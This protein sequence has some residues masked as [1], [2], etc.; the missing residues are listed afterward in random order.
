MT[1][2]I[3]K[4]RAILYESGLPSNLIKIIRMGHIGTC[5]RAKNVGRIGRKTENNKG[6]FQGSPLS[7]FLFII[8]AENMMG[9]YEKA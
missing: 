7:A 1:R 2:S 3:E 6:A 9:Y 4:L 5:L 8:Y